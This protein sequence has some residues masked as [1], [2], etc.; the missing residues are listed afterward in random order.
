MPLPTCLQARLMREKRERLEQVLADQGPPRP[1]LARGQLQYWAAAIRTRNFF[2]LGAQRLVPVFDLL[3]HSEQPNTQYQGAAG[4]GGL[5]LRCC[6][7][8]GCFSA[9]K[10][11]GS[12]KALPYPL[13]ACCPIPCCR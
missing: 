7:D 4:R 13:C 11:M 6:P 8:A 9:Q 12:I 1:G 10:P 5:A 2:L 3:N